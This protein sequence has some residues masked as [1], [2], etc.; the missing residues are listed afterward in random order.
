[1]MGLLFN[2]HFHIMKLQKNIDDN[3]KL[4]TGIKTDFKTLKSG[5]AAKAT[6]DIKAL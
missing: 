2:Q 1:M 4:M 6:I 5:G 3:T